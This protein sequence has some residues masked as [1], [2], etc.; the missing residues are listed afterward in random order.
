MAWFNKKQK[1]IPIWVTSEKYDGLILNY[2][3]HNEKNKYNGKNLNGQQLVQ[4]RKW[5]FENEDYILKRFEARKSYEDDFQRFSKTL[6]RFRKTLGYS[7]ITKTI[8]YYSEKIKELED[9]YI[10]QRK[11]KEKLTEYYNRLLEAKK[12]LDSIIDDYNKF[13]EFHLNVIREEK[14]L[15]E[16]DKESGGMK[17]LTLYIFED[18]FDLWLDLSNYFDYDYE[19]DKEMLEDLICYCEEQLNK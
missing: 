14:P 15:R 17:Y 9:T 18:I 2:F 11:I 4:M 16:E 6:G 13:E 10:S 19:E 3:K 8:N 7:D 12:E 5:C 1:E